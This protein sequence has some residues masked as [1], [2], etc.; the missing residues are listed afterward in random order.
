M[1]QLSASRIPNTTLE[2]RRPSAGALRLQA[3]GLAL[4]VAMATTW[5]GCKSTPPA[6]PFCPGGLVTTVNGKQSCAAL[7]EPSKCQNPGNVCVDNQCALQC[8]SHLDCS[9]GQSCLPA[10]EDGSGAAITTCQSNG[11]GA[12]GTKC[13]FGNECAMLK[14]CGDGTPCPATGNCTV[15]TC[16]ALTCLTR[17]SGD[18]DAYCTLDD[19]RTGADCP[20]GFAC[21]AVSDPHQICGQPAPSANLC[22]TTKDPCVD[23]TKNA[24]N[25]TT[26]AAGQ[27][28]TQRN[29]CRI[30]A[31]CDACTSD[32][33]CSLVPGRHCTM[34]NCADDCA[35]DADC[36]NGF[37]CTSG[38][39]V[40]RSGSC[41]PAT[42]GAGAFCDGCRDEADCGTGLLCDVL[43]PGGQRVCINLNAK[44]CTADTDCPKGPS[45]LYAICADARLNLQAGDPGFDTCYIAP[46]ATADDKFGCWCGNSGATCTAA[47]DCCSKSCV[48]AN[49]TLGMTGLCK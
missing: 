26:Y 37:E 14:T 29:Q 40:P 45:G 19:C 12:I 33:D 20:S 31:Q 36:V 6:P 28:C 44:S 1:S 17:G 34:G 13:P 25:G 4:A 30:L 24:A 43:A 47:A 16:Q 5:F 2:A 48:G 23:P 42:A 9:A 38:E 32:V 27:F 7:C 10:K 15:G 39:C 8:T 11:K 35:T 18:A 22:G 41:A 49:A 21:D 46:F 3:S